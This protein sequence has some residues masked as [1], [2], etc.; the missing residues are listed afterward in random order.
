MSYVMDFATIDESNRIDTAYSGPY[1]KDA[2]ELF[3]YFILINV[4]HLI[5]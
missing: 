4:M 3:D 1:D 2:M 5:K